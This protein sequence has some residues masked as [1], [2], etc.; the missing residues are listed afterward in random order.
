MIL[1][2]FDVMAGSELIS[3]NH[4]YFREDDDCEFAASGCHSE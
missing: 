2:A 3:F 4:D 1:F